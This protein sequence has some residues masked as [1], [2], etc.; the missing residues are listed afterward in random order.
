MGDTLKAPNTKQGVLRMDKI[1]TGELIREARKTKNYTQSELG[2]MLGVTNKAVSRWE[3]GE[4]FPDIGVLESLAHILDLKIQDIVVGEVQTVETDNDSGEITATEIVRMA[5]VQIQT[6]KKRI[7]S[8]VLAAVVVFCSI[9]AGIAGTSGANLLFDEASGI[10]YYLLM[11][12]SLA[13]VVYGGFAPR[14]ESE[15]RSG[16]DYLMIVLSIASYG[17]MIIMMWC[18]SILV[19]SDHIPFGMRLENVGPFI[20][21]QLSAIIVLNLLF[22][23]VEIAR[24]GNEFKR[25]HFGYVFQITAIYMAAL[26]GDL[27]HR[28]SSFDGYIQ[29]LALRTIAVLICTVVALL[30]MR[31]LNKHDDGTDQR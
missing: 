12:C 5:T 16:L 27:L 20:N 29:N 3:K 15:N 26:Y 6:R 30:S 8:L 9:V 25:L 11:I 21:T 22:L 19:V 2:D 17:W 23:I 13:A 28:L 31:L 10:V 14:Y 24:M 7:L 1:K 4:S 18:V